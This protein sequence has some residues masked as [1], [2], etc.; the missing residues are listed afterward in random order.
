[1]K[2]RITE[3]F[4]WPNLEEL[5]KTAL[6]RELSSDELLALKS[7][8]F[9]LPIWML[10]L[11]RG[12]DEINKRPII[13]ILYNL[14]REQ[15]TIED[16]N[17]EK[18]K[19]E[20]KIVLIDH[21]CY[22]INNLVK[23]NPSESIEDLVENLKTSTE[24]LK[25]GAMDDD[26]RIFV[27]HFGKGSSLRE[28]QSYATQKL[29]ED[30]YLCVT[31]M[32]TGMKRFLK[33]GKIATKNDLAEYCSY[34]AGDVGIALNRIVESTDRIK[35]NDNSAKT[36]GA[37]LQQVNIIKNINED[38]TKR[39]VA[40]IPAE[41]YADLNNEML[42]SLESEDGKRARKS[43]LETM[44]SDAR[45]CIETT[46]NYIMAIPEE[47]TGY[48]GFT[49]IPFITAVETL[50]TMEKAGAE[51]VFSGRESAIKVSK[52]VFSNI[53]DFSYSL[54][55]AKEGKNLKEFVTA[56]KLARTNGRKKE[57]SFA[58]NEFE[59][60]AEEFLGS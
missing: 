48:K 37:L 52:E 1:M 32:A 51:E 27:E 25:E 50:D 57:Y 33:M 30:I 7:R 35:L 24:A 26:E 9:Y 54:V 4:K 60:L 3:R 15:D 40:Y 23:R 18:I 20:A 22:I 12:R 46:A 31:S 19:P 13:T 58:P 38:R 47:L 44:I 56:Y 14:L 16:A 11:T 21:F 5:K 36:F 42:F 53:A 34:V 6:Q 49:L 59:K 17:P 45:E 39:C 43:I 8:S 41:L 29:K 2:N 55:Q 10:E 28:I